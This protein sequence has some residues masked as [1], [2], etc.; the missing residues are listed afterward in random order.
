MARCAMTS[1]FSP[2]QWRRLEALGFG[3]GSAN[4]AA[5]AVQRLEDL[6]AQLV[7]PWDFGAHAEVQAA[8]VPDSPLTLS[9]AIPGL[10]AVGSR[11]AY[12]GSTKNMGVVVATS[13]RDANVWWD[14]SEDVNSGWGTPGEPSEWVSRGD[15][16][17]VMTYE[18]SRDR[19]V[20]WLCPEM[21]GGAWILVTA[22]PPT[23][24]FVCLDEDGCTLAESFTVHGL[25]RA[26]PRELPDGTFRVDVEALCHVVRYIHDRRTA[27]GDNG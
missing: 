2:A 8:D 9:G 4:P 14:N 18:S 15:V 10:L 19:A 22:G 3:P 21:S 1:G 5:W 12:F 17:L 27:G 6:T 7:R 16:D 20:R 11:V 26:D 24:G 23:W 25:D 13:T